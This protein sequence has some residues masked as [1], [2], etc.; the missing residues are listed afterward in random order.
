MK[1]IPLTAVA[2]G[3]LL[4]GALLAT[5]APALADPCYPPADGCVRV[6]SSQVT[7]SYDAASNT[8]VVRLA[9]L[10]PNSSFTVTITLPTS[11]SGAAYQGGMH[12][13]AASQHTGGVTA[14][15]L[16]AN[17]TT[18]SGTADAQGVGAVRVPLG[19]FGSLS[20]AQVNALVF[21]VN[22]TAA[23]GT[24]L[25]V[26]NGVSFTGRT[27]S[28]SGSTATSSSLP[29]TGSNVVTLAAAGGALGLAGGGLVL[30]ARRRRADSTRALGV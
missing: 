3:A 1:T 25:S 14:A 19:S 5:A 21:T 23:D 29:F 11:A 20:S 18:L 9:G 22:G 4:S 30:V 24:V 12:I 2:A 27:S 10:K 6:G 28:G 26:D 15:R 17:T 13:V 16:A 8:A 7:T